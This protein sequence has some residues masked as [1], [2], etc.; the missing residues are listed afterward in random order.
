M[1]K[2]YFESKIKIAENLYRLLINICKDCPE[3]E[4]YVYKKIPEF[5]YQVIY[6]KKPIIS[7][8]FN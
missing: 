3:N 4:N 8:L 5:Q 1:K 2:N 6:I 7:A